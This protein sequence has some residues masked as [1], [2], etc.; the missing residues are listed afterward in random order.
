MITQKGNLS[1]KKQYIDS[2]RPDLCE[3]SLF[4]N[5]EGGAPLS[6]L[7]KGYVYVASVQTSGQNYFTPTYHSFSSIMFFLVDY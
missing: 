2:R 7:G 5:W 4:P 6:Q 3:N 1:G